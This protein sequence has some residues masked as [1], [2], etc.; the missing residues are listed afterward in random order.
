MIKLKKIMNYYGKYEDLVCVPENK[1]IYVCDNHVVGMM[2]KG[3]N[4]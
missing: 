4:Q 3:N 2:V 1:Y